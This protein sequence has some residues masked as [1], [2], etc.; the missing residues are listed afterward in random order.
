MTSTTPAHSNPHHEPPPDLANL[1]RVVL[2]PS[3]QRLLDQA[4]RFS[5]GPP[6][7][8]RRKLAEAADLARLAQLSRRI[9]LLHLDL[10]WDLRADILMR[11]PVPC[12]PDSTKPLTVAPIARLGF[13]YRP[14]IL[15]TPQPGFSIVHIIE[16][17]RVWHPHVSFDDHQA[18]CLGPSVS[19]SWPLRECV[20]LSYM[21]LCMVAIELDPLNPAGVLNA[22][23]CDYYQRHP[24]LLPLSREPFLLPAEVLQ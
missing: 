14:A 10:S 19:S 15:E 24:Q 11:V 18:L 16:P 8:K 21:A 20:L 2:N 6:H 13:I 1:G 5:R 23:S 3:H 22:E 12:L 7:W 9:L 17:R 4:A